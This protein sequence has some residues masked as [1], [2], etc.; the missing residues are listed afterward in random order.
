MFR[1]VLHLLLMFL[2]L[3]GVCAQ[4]I[5]GITSKAGHFI[6]IK[7]SLYEMAAS[8][9]IH[10]LK[11][12]LEYFASDSFNGRAFHYR[13]NQLATEYIASELKNMGVLP[14]N[15]NSYFQKIE[16]HRIFWDKIQ[17]KQEK[18]RKVVKQFFHKRDFYCS[19]D[20]V[21][22]ALDTIISDVVRVESIPDSSV[23]LRLESEAFDGQAV[24][25]E[26]SS[27]HPSS[28]GRIPNYT[29]ALKELGKRGASFVF[30]VD[31]NLSDRVYSDNSHI[32]NTLR[33]G[34]PP[35][36]V[37]IP[38]HIYVSQKTASKIFTS[39]TKKRHWLIALFCPNKLA[40]MRLD[41]PLHI[42]QKREVLRYSGNNVLAFF[43]G[44]RVA[45]SLVVLTAHPDHLHNLGDRIYNGADDNG[46]GSMA[47]LAIA[48]AL[49]EAEKKGLRPERSILLMWTNGEEAGLLGSKYYVAHPVYPLNNTIA[50]INVDMIGR[51]VDA[52]KQDSQYIFVIGSDRISPT[53]H[54]INEEV[55]RKYCNFTLDYRYN[56]TDD[57]NRYYFRSDHYNF[58]ERGI[59]SIFFFNGVH[60]DYHRPTDTTNKIEW[61]VF[62]N[63]VRYLFCLLWTLANDRRPLLKIKK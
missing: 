25:L 12:H 19:Y 62:R 20:E 41:I 11:D 60:S 9:P 53:L 22:H 43:P 38:N 34:T 14:G 24:V 2:W 44:T 54:T 33:M 56:A 57:P 45:D 29:E 23:H 51:V 61:V 46:S 21:T 37:G 17:F 18:G 5:S 8:I 55:N 28:E 32:G 30:I 39:T 31:P 58:A 15:G 52:Y 50:E 63:R 13:E 36:S 3:Q 10:F 47:L 35:V 7:D 40:G 16:Y 59:P 49:K 42:R 26:S 48:Q 1:V 27:S 6:P 4:Y